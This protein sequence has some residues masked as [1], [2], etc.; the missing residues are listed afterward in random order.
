[1]LSRS[2]SRLAHAHQRAVTR[3]LSSLAPR[4]LSL[5]SLRPP[6]VASI[7]T[8]SIPSNVRSF[9]STWT[10]L[11]SRRSWENPVS[12]EDEDADLEGEGDTPA[13]DV[14]DQKAL[15]ADSKASAAASKTDPAAAD[16]SSAATSTLTSKTSQKPDGLPEDFFSS[17]S[18]STSTSTTSPSSSISTATGSGSST[19]TSSSVPPGA[20]PSSDSTSPPPAAAAAPPSSNSPPAT[21]EIKPKSRGNKGGRSSKI[22]VIKTPVPKYDQVLVIPV[23]TSFLPPWKK[24]F[25]VT[26]PAVIKAVRHLISEKIDYVGVYSLKGEN[27]DIIHDKSEVHTT[28]LYCHIDEFQ[29]IS[30]PAGQTDPDVEE[31]WQMRL[32]PLSRITIDSVTVEENATGVVENETVIAEAN[33]GPEAGVT[34]FEKSED[35][36]QPVTK[37]SEGRSSDEVTS[38]ESEPEDALPT[39]TPIEVLSAHPVSIAQITHVADSP[40]P[41]KNTIAYSDLTQLDLELNATFTELCE[42]SPGYRQALSSVLPEYSAILT[43]PLG[44]RCDLMAGTSPNTTPVEIQELLDCVS[45]EE[46]SKLVTRI[47]RNEVMR[48]DMRAK[49]AGE[50]KSRLD[51]RQK[52]VILMEQMRAIKKELGQ[53]DGKGDVKDNLVEKFKQA[54]EGLVMPEQVKQVFDSELSKLSMIEPNSSE[55]NVVRTY[56]EWITSLPF[57]K[58]TV[59]SF[60]L[61]QSLRI[62]NE[63]HYGLKDVKDRI[64]EFLAV[65]KLRGTVEGKILCLVGPPGVG[66]TSIAKSIARALERKF[67]RV[68]V[69]GLRDVAEIKGHRRTYVAAMPGKAVQALKQTQA[70]NPLIL[71][72]EIDKISGGGSANG[73]YGG[74]P[75]SALLEMLDPEQNGNFTDHYMDLPIDLSKVL[76]VCTANMLNTIPAPLLDRMEVLEVSGYVSDEKKEIARNYLMPQAKKASGLETADVTI[77]DGAVDGLIQYYCRESGVRNLK[78][79][80]EKIY[81][82]AAFKIVQ[83]IDESEP[84]KTE[85]E[86]EA[87]T[88]ATTPPAQGTVPEPTVSSA[89]LEAEAE[90]VTSSSSELKT[91]SE[92]LPTGTTTTQQ[93]KP[94]S[95]P[96][97]V[98]M[99]ITGDNLKDY[100]GP[101]VYQKD[102]IYSTAPPPGVSNGLGYTGNGAGALMPIEV[103]V[104][105]GKGAV[106]TTGKLG[107]V[108]NESVK[109][110]V[111]YLRANAFN[112]GIVSKETDIIL[113]G[114]SDQDIHLHMPEGA[115]GK[116]GPSAGTAIL[117]ALVSLMTKT[118]VDPDIAMTGEITLGGQV[119]PVGGLK[120]KILAAH[121]ANIKKLIVPAACRGDIEANVHASVKQGIEII[122]VNHVREVL[123]EVFGDLHGQWKDKYPLLDIYMP[124][125]AKQDSITL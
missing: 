19:S 41:A 109:I 60:N 68:S 110:A 1:M 25:T 86:V 51:E 28:G 57:G 113:G 102:R 52:E 66:K 13:A 117:T 45:L 56:L 71:I 114:N 39:K 121:R 63:D 50:M 46:R 119:L 92:T 89:T 77:E 120:E 88:S 107:E 111:S 115:I 122:Y 124:E 84:A 44:E 11:S 99:R 31:A 101:P 3:T 53:A 47:L 17:Q 42:R 48:H 125:S 12:K 64:L 76:F 106:Q 96:T 35:D 94:L 20:S 82:K 4:I 34:S 69:G 18:T 55:F 49:I 116:D 32:Q 74:D 14:K 104:M 100:V 93:V 70:E 83:D 78:K 21:A 90:K 108:I 10:N 79:Q 2:S 73:S 81:R 23:T 37:K 105:P 16:P 38:F 72:D 61:P 30:A 5:N 6:P 123:Y 91:P 97:T 26:N 8:A 87:A 80:I 24:F 98:S 9:S 75:S 58:R 22:K 43:L 65:G 33:E 29:P 54:A 7:V 85:V 40:A 67:Y 27:T 36:T 112:L 62:L 95:I 103:T 118:R 59:D 15:E